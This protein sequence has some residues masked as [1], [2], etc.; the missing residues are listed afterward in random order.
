MDEQPPPAPEFEAQ[1]LAKRLLRTV[2]A[3]ALATLGREAGHPF[4]SL[5]TVATDLDGSP[6]MLMS[7]LAAHTLNLERDPRASLLL[8]Q[9][10][11]G[12]PLAHPRLT[13]IGRAERSAEPRVRR[14]F[15]A[16]HPKAS[17]YADFGDFSFW[18]LGV[19]G[20]HLIGG[21]GRIVDPAADQLRTDL[22]GA[23][24]LIA[25][26]ESALAHM[27]E[28]HRDALALYATALA[29]MPPGDWR[30]TGLDPEGI[31]LMAGE[32]TARVPY[33]ERV[34]EPGRLRAVLKAL[35][36]E[37]RKKAFTA[38]DDGTLAAAKPY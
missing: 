38:P 2:R 7:R 21:F 29:G 11:K 36:D 4:A 33:P 34:A 31:D 3:G 19:E 1:A 25:A 27:N 17:L 12:D 8:A 37:A 9:G 26:E 10:G 18:R 28:D 16:R 13:V 15:F 24:A 32:L 23:E 30:A 6:L 20:A 22:T 14:R 35:A 5:V